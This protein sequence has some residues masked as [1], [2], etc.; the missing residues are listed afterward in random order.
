LFSFGLD[1]V[2]KIVR[3]KL[4][5][6]LFYVTVFSWTKYNKLL[7][8]Y[9]LTKYVNKKIE[10]LPFSQQYFVGRITELKNTA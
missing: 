5:T 1:T 8:L 3:A 2:S 6:V 7:V 9:I 4:K 10:L